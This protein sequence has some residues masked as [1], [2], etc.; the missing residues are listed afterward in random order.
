VRK[1]IESVAAEYGADEVFVVNILYDPAMRLR[2]YELI[3]G[4]FGLRGADVGR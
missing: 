2:S 4:V 1:T 3:A